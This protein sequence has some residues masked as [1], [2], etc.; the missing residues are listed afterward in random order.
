M[1]LA[2]KTVRTIKYRNRLKHK[3]KF[4][5]VVSSMA[6]STGPPMLLKYYYLYEYIGP[7]IHELTSGGVTFQLAMFLIS[8]ETHDG[9]KMNSLTQNLQDRP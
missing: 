6:A 4:L 8:M 2:N 7:I 1:N 3:F 5:L 9:H